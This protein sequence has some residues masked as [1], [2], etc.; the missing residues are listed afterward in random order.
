MLHFCARLVLPEAKYIHLPHKPLDFEA[1]PARLGPCANKPAKATFSLRR[2]LG[3][4]LGARRNSGPVDCTKCAYLTALADRPCTA[5]THGVRT[6]RL[7]CRAESAQP[8]M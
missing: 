7:H 3:P 6:L 2:V 1:V 4:L 5:P 8:R